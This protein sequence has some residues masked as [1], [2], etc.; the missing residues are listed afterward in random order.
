MEAMPNNIFPLKH[1]ANQYMKWQWLCQCK[2]QVVQDYT[3][4][5]YKMKACINIKEREN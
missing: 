2:D 1:Y 3:N 4:I 5:L